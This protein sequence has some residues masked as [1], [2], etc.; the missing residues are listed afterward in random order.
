M[1]LED[2]KLKVGLAPEPENIIWEKV[3]HTYDEWRS[4]HAGCRIVMVVV[5]LVHAAGII[6]LEVLKTYLL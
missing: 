4:N 1:R 3:E 5:P 6:G 2:Y